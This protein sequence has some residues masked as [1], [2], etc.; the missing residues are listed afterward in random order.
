MNNPISAI[1]RIREPARGGVDGAELADLGQSVG[2]QRRGRW[3]SGR[4]RGS[5]ACRSAAALAA[6]TTRTAAITAMIP[7]GTFTS[8]IQRQDASSMIRPPSVGP[9]IGASIAGTA[10]QAHH[11]AHPLGPGGLGHH[12]LADRKDHAAAE[13]LEHPE[14]D[15]LGARL[16]EPAEP[17]SRL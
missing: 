2:Q 10:H 6:G 13:A 17:R 11:P 14:Q 9:K 15:Q 4:G 12:Q 5:Q 8:K 16:R 1:P 7:I 3:P